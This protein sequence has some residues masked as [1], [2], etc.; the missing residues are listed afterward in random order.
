MTKDTQLKLFDQYTLYLRE[1]LISKGDDYAGSEDRLS[2]FKSAALLVD[3]TPSQQCLSLIATKVSRLSTLLRD[4]NGPKNEPI[5]DSCL[6]LAN[7]AFLLAM[8]EYENQYH[9]P[10]TG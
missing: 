3:T 7:Y 4:G 6:D 5:K 10:V 8:L 9:T 2:N 1:L